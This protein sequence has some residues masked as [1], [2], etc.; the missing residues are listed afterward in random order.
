[1][2]MEETIWEIILIK[3][4]KDNKFTYKC[5]YT[6]VSSIF[7]SRTTFLVLAFILIYYSTEGT[8]SPLDKTSRHVTPLPDPG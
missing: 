3:K 1:M 7:E 5:V 8:T 4:D 2:K 6:F